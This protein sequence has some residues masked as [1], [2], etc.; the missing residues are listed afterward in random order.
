[1]EPGATGALISFPALAKLLVRPRKGPNLLSGCIPCTFRY[2]HVL[3][4]KA[5]ANLAPLELAIH[6]LA[7]S[8]QQDPTQLIASMKAIGMEA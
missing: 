3:S 4:Q 2:A 5:G 6:Q 1:M 7:P 8:L